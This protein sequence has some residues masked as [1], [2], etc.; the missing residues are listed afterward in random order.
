MFDEAVV[1]HE[2]LLVGVACKLAPEALQVCVA[3]RAV[4]EEGVD[5]FEVDVWG[6]RSL[7]M[8]AIWS[9]LQQ[10]SLPS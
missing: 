5:G 6:E 1:S 3:E 7:H 9:S 10:T 4:A 2:V 8:R